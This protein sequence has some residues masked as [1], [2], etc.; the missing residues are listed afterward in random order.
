MLQAGTTIVIGTHDTDLA[1]EWAEDAWVV[2]E[3]RIA[4]R[5]PIADVM[6]KR[7]M[8][9]TAHLRMP[10][11]VEMALAMQD[12]EPLPA[13]RP[14]PATRKEMITRIEQI[15]GRGFGAGSGL[16]ASAARFT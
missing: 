4:A 9:R 2:I 10:Y 5:G 8:L 16:L 14:L 6:R 3:G 7:E 1:Y 15:V 12:G 13:N 11:L